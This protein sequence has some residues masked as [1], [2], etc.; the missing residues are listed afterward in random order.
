MK[1][2]FKCIFEWMLSDGIFLEIF[3]KDNFVD[4]CWKGFGFV[5]FLDVKLDVLV[6]E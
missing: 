1:I 6:M 5:E 3:N 2:F 4:L